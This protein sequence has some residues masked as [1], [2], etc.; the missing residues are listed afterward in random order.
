MFKD[1]EKVYEVLKQSDE[2]N[3]DRVLSQWSQWSRF[4][5]YLN[6][7]APGVSASMTFDEIDK[8][9]EDTIIKK[10]QKLFLKELLECFY[11]VS[12]DYTSRFSDELD[13]NLD[14][15]LSDKKG[16]RLPRWQMYGP[17]IAKYHKDPTKI[18]HDI[19]KHG[20]A[21]TY[22][23]DFIRE[24]I[25][26]PGYKFALTTLAYF[27][28]DY[29]DGQIDFC[30]GKELYAFKPKAG[31][32]LMFPSGHP[33][34]LSK[35]GNVY[36]HGVIAPKKTNKYL[37]RMYWRRYS[38]GDQQWFDKEKEFGTEVWLSMQEQIMEEYRQQYPQRFEISEGVRIK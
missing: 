20:M 5:D 30:I 29:E 12:I 36:L 38:E 37:A 9:E 13:F 1:I 2:G 35:D 34:V 27:N 7:T 14:E 4:G 24:P 23:S 25:V 26:S 3:E 18:S 11:A 28:D 31:D 32:F 16:N 8:L 10:N 19:E 22:H 17:S 33:E 21:M 15:I 6:P